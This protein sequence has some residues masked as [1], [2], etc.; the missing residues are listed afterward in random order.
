LI[1]KS[2]KEKT[3]TFGVKACHKNLANQGPQDQTKKSP[4]NSREPNPLTNPTMPI[5]YHQS[6]ARCRCRRAIRVY[7]ARS[8]KIRL[9]D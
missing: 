9:D 6:K 1:E 8:I 2:R 5:N 4:K 3:F 7:L